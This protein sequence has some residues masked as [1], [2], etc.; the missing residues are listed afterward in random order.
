[1]FDVEIPCDTTKV[2]PVIK[3]LPYFIKRVLIDCFDGIGNPLLN[4]S[5]AF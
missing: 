1:M 3:L 4:V 5:Y 2:K